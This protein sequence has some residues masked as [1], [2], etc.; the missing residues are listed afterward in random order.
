MFILINCQS[1]SDSFILPDRF[2]QTR[3]YHV[4]FQV[5]LMLEVFQTGL[6]LTFIFYFLLWPFI[7]RTVCVCFQIFV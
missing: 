3:L 7:F 4:S 1:Q 6:S 2:I 5:R